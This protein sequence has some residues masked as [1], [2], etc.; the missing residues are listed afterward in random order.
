MMEATA[1]LSTVNP[2]S[3]AVKSNREE[4]KQ[5][6]LSRAVLG[7]SFSNFP[8]IFQGFAAKGIPET[9]IKPRENVFIESFIVTGETGDFS[10]NLLNCKT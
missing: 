6:A 2:Q 5:E 4:E 10:P 1:N 3:K 7:Q 9:E 8:A